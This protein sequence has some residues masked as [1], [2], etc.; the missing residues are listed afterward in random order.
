[1]KI[2]VSNI[3]KLLVSLGIGFGLIY[4]VTSKLSPQDK[5]DI[6]AAIDKVD[7]FWIFTSMFIAF[8]ACIVRAIRW[9]MLIEP[10]GYKPRVSVTIY[11]VFILYIG[12]LLFPRL[13]EIMRC[14]IIARYEKIPLDQGIG[15]MVTERIIDVIGILALCSMALFFEMDVILLFIEKFYTGMHFEFNLNVMIVGVLILASVMAFGVFLMRKLKIHE[16][17][18][19]VKDGFLTG[20]RT[21][22]QLENPWLFIFYS[23]VIYISYW[24]A[25]V[26]CFKA[27]S[28]TASLHSTAGL[29]CLF[30]SS[31]GVIISQGGIGAYQLLTQQTLLLYNISPVIGYAFGWVTWLAQTSMLVIGGIVS[32]ILLS[33]VKKR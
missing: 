5:L 16:K 25:V 24:L 15:T 31:I 33:F 2:S 26:A 28:E 14:A 27:M 20:F 30:A 22:F 9:I 18:N 11:S 10:L 29:M 13:G 17:V 6:W 23:L 1:M 19:A 32:L 12:N 21:V 8:L 7:Y 3:L 4:M